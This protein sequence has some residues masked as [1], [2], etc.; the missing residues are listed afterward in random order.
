MFIFSA[1][2]SK[3]TF[4]QPGFGM[5]WIDAENSV[6]ENLCDVPTFFRHR[7]SSVRPIDSNV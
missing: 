5:A 2:L 6:K 4:H 7:S 1:V 3:V